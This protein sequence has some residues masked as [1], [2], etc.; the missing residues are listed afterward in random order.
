VKKKLAKAAANKQTKTATNRPAGRGAS[1]RNVVVGQ[2]DY[3]QKFHVKV[4]PAPHPH[5]IR[6]ENWPANG[7]TGASAHFRGWAGILKEV[8]MLLISKE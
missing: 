8:S 3:T 4:T 1:K 7:L 5:E 6:W 2:V